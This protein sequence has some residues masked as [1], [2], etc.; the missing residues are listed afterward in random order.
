MLGDEVQE[1]QGLYGPFTLSERVLQKIWLRQ[2]FDTCNLVT[3]A[4]KQLEV[5]NPGKW[6]LLGGPDFKDATLRLNG[7]ELRGDVEVHFDAADWYLHA[8]ERNAA[9]D[10]VILHVLLYRPEE[11]SR[12]VKTLN[13]SMPETLVLMPLLQRDLESIAMDE[14]LLEME[15]VNELEWVAE[16]L[17]LPAKEREVRLAKATCR[18]WG[19]KLHFAAMRLERHGWSDACH[20]LCLEVLGYSRNREPMARLALEYPLEAM[21]GGSAEELFQ[22][23]QKDWKLSGVRPANHPRLRLQQYLTVLEAAPAWPEQIETAMRNLPAGSQGLGTSSLRREAEL[24]K[25]CAR[26]R[27]SVFGNQLG[28]SRFHTLMIDALLPLAEVAGVLNAEAYW[29]HWYVGDVPVA[30]KNFLKLVE[31][32][33]RLQ[34]N[35]NGLTQGALGLFCNEGSRL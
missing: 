15:R 16:F 14:A 25:W 24:S 23:V 7:S 6:N 4:G 12:K 13:G 35:T 32:T 11:D 9:F 2:Q 30:L 34:P 26:V 28:E 31:A 17:E 1:V 19:H 18:R 22:R 3:L 29:Q 21:Q 10:R 27:E 8:H 5:L 33:S 20:Q